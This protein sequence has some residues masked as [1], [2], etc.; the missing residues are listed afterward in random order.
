MLERLETG[1]LGIA[2]YLP[3]SALL[4]TVRKVAVSPCV[5]AGSPWLL[6]I[7]LLLLSEPWE[8]GCVSR[9]PG[10]LPSGF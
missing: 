4:S 2:K 9:L 1:V 7:P 8:V 10:S 3:A 6:Q 5:P